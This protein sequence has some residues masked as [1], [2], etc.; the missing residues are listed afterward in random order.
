M[1]ILD[2]EDAVSP[3][4]KD[5]ARSIATAVVRERPYGDREV[6]LRVNGLDTG[7]GSSDLEAAVAA[8]PDGILVPK[9]TGAVD[10]ARVDNALNDADA[11][12]HLGLWVMIE[13]PLA[14]LNIKE[15][16]AMANTSRLSG[17]VMGTNDLAKEAGIHPTNDRA[18][19]QVA[20]S[21]SLMAARAYGLAAIDGV[22][23]D[24]KTQSGL[25]SECEQGRI[26]GFDGKTLVHPSQI[27]ACNQAF[28]PDP[29]AV[30]HAKSVIAAFSE[31][32]NVGKGV[33][34]VDGRMV[35]LLHLEQARRL[36]SL[37]EAIDRMT[38][39]AP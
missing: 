10:I 17:L 15:I 36:V 35:E 27:E 1:L 13:M 38:P 8:A 31:P 29:D 4:A 23:N 30:R 28:T 19:F 11:P 20:L 33:L 18:G 6:L 14:I 37:S 5:E 25:V 39:P 24:I 26:L 3:E 2:L 9:V 32:A 12:A 16:A 21:L 7:W 22:Y 34:T